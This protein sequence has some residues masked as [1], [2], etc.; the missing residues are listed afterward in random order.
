MTVLYFAE[1]QWRRYPW[2]SAA[3]FAVCLFFSIVLVLF[4]TVSV[5][6]RETKSAF[7]T[8][9]ELDNISVSAFASGL[10]KEV[11]SERK[12]V[13]SVEATYSFESPLGVIA[14]PEI[15][16][17]DMMG[18][19]IYRCLTGLPEREVAWY[20]REKGSSLILCGRDILS[21]GEAI[22]DESVLDRLGLKAEE[23]ACVLGASLVTRYMDYLTKEYKEIARWT[24]VG[25]SEGSFKT[26]VL[27]IEGQTPLVFVRASATKKPSMYKVYPEQGMFGATYRSLVDDFGEENVREARRSADAQARFSEYVAFFD[28]VFVFLVALLCASFLGVTVF[29]VVFYTAKQSEFHAVAASFGAR[30]WK[31]ILSE[32]L[33]YAVLLLVSCLAAC[34]VSCLLQ[35]SVTQV[36]GG[37]FGAELLTV[38]AGGVFLVG[39]AV[40]GALVLSVAAGV[41]LGTLATKR[42]NL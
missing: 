22:L 40:F 42:R 15:G 16:E 17:S 9:H 7:V 5:S 28:R 39:A 3:Y 8:E 26:D 13:E 6:M 25:V 18:F 10:T 11:L 31:L 37:Y 20:E 19:Y 27:G 34:A 23:Y 12:Y 4:G 36:L 35:G 2:K 24:V 14:S 1:K 33:F 30:R 21:E 29:A 32:I 38:A 41:L